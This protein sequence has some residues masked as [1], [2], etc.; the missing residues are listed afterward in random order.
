MTDSL[1]KSLGWSP[2][3]EVFLNA[4]YV[5]H[6]ADQH[7]QRQQALIEAAPNRSRYTRI[8]WIDNL[9]EAVA[10]KLHDLARR[11]DPYSCF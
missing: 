8:Y 1:S 10:E 6:M 2:E 7:Y 5:D 4:D 9:R 11:I 3:A